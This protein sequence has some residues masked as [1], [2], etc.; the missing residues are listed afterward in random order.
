MRRS[1]MM[2]TVLDL[3]RAK[4][5]ELQSAWPFL[6][7]VVQGDGL[8]VNLEP[9]QATR[10]AAPAEAAAP[11]AYTSTVIRRKVKPASK[12][13]KPARKRVSKADKDAA[14]RVSAL[15]LPDA[16]KRSGD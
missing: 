5:R 9:E 3:P 14:Q 15:S 11:P 2:R 12:E 4:P 16:W 6:Y 8:V 10:L 13:K 7:S 1:D